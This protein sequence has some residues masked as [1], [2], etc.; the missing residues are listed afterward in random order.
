M[1]H[2]HLLR[3]ERLA[4]GVSRINV[5]SDLSHVIEIPCLLRGL[6]LYRDEPSPTLEIRPQRVIYVCGRQLSHLEVPQVLL[7]QREGVVR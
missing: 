6:M 7:P 2:Q 4:P 3:P 1:L 5:L